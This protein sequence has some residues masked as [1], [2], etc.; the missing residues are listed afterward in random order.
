MERYLAQTRH[1]VGVERC[2]VLPQLDDETDLVGG[3]KGS[4]R[5]EGRGNW[6][7]DVKNNRKRFLKAQLVSKGGW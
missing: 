3:G 2:L 5:R 6:G 4:R 1:S 7:W